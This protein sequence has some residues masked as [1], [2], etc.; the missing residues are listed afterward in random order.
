MFLVKGE[1]EMEKLNQAEYEAVLSF[2]K[3]IIEIGKNFNDSNKMILCDKI[4]SLL[5][6][7]Y[8]DDSEELLNNIKDIREFVEALDCC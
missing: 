3:Q 4:N 5:T 1:M 2:I 7:Y 6:S 8:E